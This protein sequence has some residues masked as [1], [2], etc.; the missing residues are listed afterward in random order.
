MPGI[1][2]SDVVLFIIGI[3][4]MLILLPVFGI[5]LLVD[6]IIDGRVIYRRRK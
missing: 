3:P 2:T 4:I 1:K 5:I 6:R